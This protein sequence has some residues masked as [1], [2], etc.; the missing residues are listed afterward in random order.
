MTFLWIFEL[1]LIVLVFATDV[2]T[3]KDVLLTIE[4]RVV[5]RFSHSAVRCSYDLENNTLYAVKWYRG[6]YEFYRFTPSE[7]TTI[8]VFAIRGI[9][10]DIQNSNPQ[11]VVLRNID[12]NLSGNFSCEV[13]TDG[14]QF[15]TGT[16]TKVMTVVR[17]YHNSET[18][19]RNIY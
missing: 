14:P 18:I 8:K 2:L 3:L 4:P 6:G 7:S 16:D 11:Q 5:Q 10:V 12:F 15:H 19:R 13:T 1:L 9:D 17:M